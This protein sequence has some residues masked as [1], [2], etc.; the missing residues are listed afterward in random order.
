M[1]RRPLR[2]SAA[3]KRALRPVRKNTFVVVDASDLGL[4][5]ARKSPVATARGLP[6][7]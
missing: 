6:W 4:K 5:M 7:H 1:S 2:L 3:Q